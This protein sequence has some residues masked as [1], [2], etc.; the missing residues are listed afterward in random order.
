MPNEADEADE[1]SIRSVNDLTADW[2]RVAVGPGAGRGT[3]FSAAAVWPLLALLAA[4]ADGPA[5]LELR[6]V[7]GVPG[8]AD[9]AERGRRLIGTLRA[10]DGVDAAVGLWTRRDVPVRPVWAARLP[11]GVRGDLTGDA[12][13]D[14]RA[15]DAW[16]AEHTDGAI[17]SMPVPTGPDLAL[18]LAGALLVRTR[19]AVPFSEGWLTP[20][21]GPWQGR[22][23]A[24]LYRTTG[25]LDAVRVAPDTPAG[26]LTLV[27]VRG[28]N[29]LDV[30]LVLGAEN[31][32][33]ADVLAAAPA[34]LAG[35]HATVP[36]S[37]LPYGTPG[38]GVTVADATGWDSRPALVTSTARWTV[39][40]EHDLL[41][42]PEAFGL[43]SATDRSAGHFPGISPVPLAVS[44]ARQNT[45]AAF[46]ARGFEAAAVTAF[47]MAASGVP[48][49]RFRRVFASFARPHGFLAVHRQTGL[50]LA[51]GW[52]TEPD[53]APDHP[54]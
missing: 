32:G 35:D 3:V 6:A 16:A 14:G 22:R 43:R 28:D 41:E 31:A 21:T 38:P 25:D 23:L 7:T 52:V 33:G 37:A 34:V 53:D 42:R 10:A 11:E 12:E 13:R 15:L 51:A 4:G 19:W 46:T 45:V 2:A 30:H 9:A 26:P 47:G 40:A 44:S 54:W 36:G 49:E 1:A 39:R 20:E 48:N 50:I 24:G 18:V 8:A 5:R 17:P 27:E 29:G